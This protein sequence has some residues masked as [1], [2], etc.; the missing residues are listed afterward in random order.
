V[1]KAWEAVIPTDQAFR[2]A[3]RDGVIAGATLEPFVP[4]PA[5]GD[6][7]VASLRKLPPSVQGLEVTFEPDPHAWDGRFANNGWMQEL[8]DGMHRMTWGNAAALSPKTAGE[9]G[10]KDGDVL[11][12]TVNGSSV[13]VPAL[14]APGHADDSMTLTLGQGRQVGTVAKGVGVDVYPLRRSEALDIAA[15]TAVSTGVHSV[16]ARTQEHFLQAGRPMVLN[17]TAAEYAKTGTVE[18]KDPKRPA[19]LSLWKER[20]YSQG[21]AWGMSIDLNQC[22]GCN[23]CVVAC[24]SENNIPVVG[25][26]GVIDTREMH[27]LRIDRYFASDDSNPEVAAAD[28][29]SFAQPMLC[30]QCENAPC[31]QVCPVGATVHSPEGL[32]DMAYNRCIGTKYCGNNCPFKVRRFNYFNY[33]KEVPETRKAQF[34]PDVTIRARGVMEKCTFCV[35]RINTAK[36]AAHKEGRE[37]VRDG[38]IV[39]ACQQACPTSAIHFGDLNDPKSEVHARSQSHRAY[40]LLEELNIKPR[41]SYLARIKNPNP[42]LAGA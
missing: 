2:K 6:A 37:R 20:D 28:P 26:Q 23:A 7:V 15:A 16:L 9:L 24:Q 31:E 22:I 19:L 8:P 1:R 40:K 21:H 35:Q 14:L 27:W 41:V 18:T 17:T 11:A 3:L 33:A 25:R 30:N 13:Q 36:I 39:T 12:I 42:E 5:R 4:G 32:N 10:V 38:E 34:N 29:E